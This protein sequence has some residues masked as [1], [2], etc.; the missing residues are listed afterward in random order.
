MTLTV[1]DGLV[2]IGR[3]VR[4]TDHLKAASLPHSAQAYDI[5][6]VSV[7]AQPAESRHARMTIAPNNVQPVQ[8]ACAAYIAILHVLP[9]YYQT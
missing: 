8:C 1:A 2:P 7:E 3:P 6:P 4:T 9:S 5:T